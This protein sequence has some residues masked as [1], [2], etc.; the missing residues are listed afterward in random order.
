MHTGQPR[1]GHRSRLRIGA[2]IAVVLALA[3]GGAWWAVAGRGPVIRHHGVLMTSSGRAPGR[4]DAAQATPGSAA[5]SGKATRSQPAGGAAAAAIAKISQLT[6]PQLAGQ[7][8]IYSYSGLN[9][10][11]QLLQL[12]RHGQAAGVIF[13]TQNI[14]SPA[15]IAA[16]ARELEQASASPGNPVRLP[17]LLMTDQEGGEVRRLPGPP[18]LSEKQIGESAHPAAQARLAGRGAAANLRSAGLNVDLAPVLD[19]YRQPGNFIDQFGRSYSS[20]P[21]QVSYLGA[22]FIGALQRGGVAATA[23]HF[24][25]LGAAATSQ[26]TDERPVTLNLTASQIRGTDEQPYGAAIA[27]GTRLVMLSWARYPALAPRPAGLSKTIVQ[28][29]LRGR[30][31][32]TG[33]TITD[34]LEAGALRPYG[35]IPRR[36]VLAA[37]AGMQ[38]L[39]CSGQDVTEGIQARGALAAS[40]ASGALRRAAFRADVAAILT[41]R[42][43]LPR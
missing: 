3:A 28:G 21:H 39:L 35:G 14:S 38:L 18:Y 42:A 1:S 31:G 17:L 12:I 30:L 15:Q 29:E 27:A 36:A 10:P 16:V 7:R 20:S 41:L 33:V 40:Y 37:G 13:F 43:S 26:D 32:F 2:A 8:V 9:P 5:G 24:P 25:G 34:A 11:A 19:V 23:K 4:H 22:D 6:G